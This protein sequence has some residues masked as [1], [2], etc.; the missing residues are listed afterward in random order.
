MSQPLELTQKRMRDILDRKQVTHTIDS[1]G[2]IV[3]P[4][5]ADQNCPYGVVCFISLTPEGILTLRGHPDHKIPESRFAE[6]ILF[7]N[8]WNLEK[9]WPTAYSMH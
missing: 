8:R 6:A 5:N 7:C 1:D 3:I 9:R 2:D 4:L